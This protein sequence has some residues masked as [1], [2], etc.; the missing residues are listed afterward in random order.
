L[1]QSHL[2]EAFE[3]LSLLLEVWTFLV[4]IHFIVG[5]HL[6]FVFKMFECLLQFLYI[7][8]A[9]IGQIIALLEE[10]F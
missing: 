9:A 6:K 8:G 2:V 5:L 10:L 1:V 4:Q 7:L 3:F